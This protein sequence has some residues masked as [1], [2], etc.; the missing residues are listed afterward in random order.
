MSFDVLSKLLHYLKV[1]FPFRIK[2]VDISPRRTF[3]NVCKA[4]K[5]AKRVIA[6]AIFIYFVK[7]KK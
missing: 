2:I 5:V 1:F 3:L 6:V 7:V 4:S